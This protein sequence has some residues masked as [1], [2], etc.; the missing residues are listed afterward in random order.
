MNST[1]ESIH[2]GVP[3]ICIPISADQPLVAY[4]ISY[5]LGLGIMFDY[6]KMDKNDLRTG[7]CKVLTD[8]TYYER[9]QQF[10]FHSRKYKGD[11]NGAKLI[12]D[13]LNKS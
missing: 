12:I 2:F 4:R 5:D 13:F 1:N 3:M 7:L 6:E 11:L 8:Q 9:T 10:S